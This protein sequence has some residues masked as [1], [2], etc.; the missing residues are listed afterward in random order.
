MITQSKNGEKNIAT[1]NPF[2]EPSLLHFTIGRPILMGQIAKVRY[3][4]KDIS[5]FET[6]LSQIYT[7][8]VS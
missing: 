4:D 8:L 7:Y 2:P 6:I 1:I 5:K 3:S